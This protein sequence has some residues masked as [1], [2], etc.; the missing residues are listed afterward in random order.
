MFQNSWQSLFSKSPGTERLRSRVTLIQLFR[1]GLRNQIEIQSRVHPK[2]QPPL[3]LHMK[4]TVYQA[5]RDV[6]AGQELTLCYL[7][8]LSLDK[9]ARQAKTM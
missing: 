2:H 8:D 7:D 4:Q 5:T 3:Q 6:R 9:A 1:Q